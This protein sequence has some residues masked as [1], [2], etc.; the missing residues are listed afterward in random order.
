MRIVA[1]VVTTLLH[2]ALH[3][4]VWLRVIHDAGVPE[5]VRTIALWVF[6]GL[7]LS[8]RF[9][10]AFTAFVRSTIARA[11]MLP[12]NVWTAFLLFVIPPLMI[13]DLARGLAGLAAADS[14]LHGHAAAR[15]AA[16][17]CSA[18][19]L[20]LLAAGVWQG[21]RVRVRELRIPLDR[22]PA[23]LDGT[24]LVQLT[25]VHIGAVLGGSFLE[26]IVDR[27]NALEPDL[28][29]IT[30]D[31]VDGFPALAKHEIAAV[32]RLR[33]RYGVFFVTGNHEIDWNG[34]EWVATLEGLG[35]RALRNTRVSIG[36]ERA[37]FDLAGVEDWAG[38]HTGR[39]PDLD[40]AVAGRDPSRELVLLAHQPRMIHAAAR[41]GVGLQLSGHTHAGQI[42]PWAP[43]VRL[44]Q[45]YL[46]GLIRHEGTWLY[47][48][49]GTGLWGPPVR[50]GTR[51]EITRCVL[52]SAKSRGD[53]VV[54]LR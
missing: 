25:D 40:A 54:D 35:V 15:A 5:P 3:L 7:S 50:L 52:L 1:I 9:V 6:C 36:T 49:S 48:S 45:P 21:R 32:A 17:G 44:Q 47:V 8:I 31:L 26:K 14:P 42:W 28:V 53:R 51:P 27:V 11:V 18:L 2:L 30:G 41:A 13:F 29:A 33:A 4:Y 12:L 20:L 43:L 46:A 39:P 10:P 24:T 23:E 22:L 37:S 34:D 16:I 38:K 19:A